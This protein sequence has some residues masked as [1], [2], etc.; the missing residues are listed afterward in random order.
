MNKLGLIILVAPFL[1][2]FIYFL[3]SCFS[4]FS[5]SLSYCSKPVLVRMLPLLFL[6]NFL[7]AQ[8]GIILKNKAF[9]SLLLSLLCWLM[10]ATIM[11]FAHEHK[12]V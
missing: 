8:D 11:Y 9:K 12:Y 10:A 1:V 2:G 5:K 3:V 6:S 4:N 7:F